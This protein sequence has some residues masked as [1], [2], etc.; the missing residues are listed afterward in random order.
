MGR[1]KRCPGRRRRPAHASASPAPPADGETGA[2]AHW[3]AWVSAQDFG[4]ILKGCGFPV[5]SE[6]LNLAST[7]SD[8]SGFRWIECSVLSNHSDP[9]LENLPELLGNRVGLEFLDCYGG[10]SKVSF[11]YRQDALVTTNG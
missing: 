8:Q 10:V 3:K 2:L 4:D 5:S 1:H 7:Q 6:V 11:S 9:P